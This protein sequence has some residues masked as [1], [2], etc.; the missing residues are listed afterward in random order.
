MR[1]TDT[2][3]LSTTTG[4]PGHGGITARLTVVQSRASA[5]PEPGATL[6]HDAVR[7]QIIRDTDGEDV[8][9]IVY[10]EAQAGDADATDIVK[11]AADAAATYLE[12]LRRQ[13]LLMSAPAATT[14]NLN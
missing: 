4:L 13:G 14:D 12:D 2:S 3:T 1:S 5:L 8:T 7:W 10:R 9:S 6:V 11:A